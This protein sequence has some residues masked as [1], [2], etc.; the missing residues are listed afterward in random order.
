MSDESYLSL[1]TENSF[2]DNMKSLQSNLSKIQAQ[3]DPK[4]EEYQNDKLAFSAQRAI[5]SNLLV[6]LPTVVQRVVDKPGQGSVYALTNLI[7][8]IN[9]LFGQLRSSEAL[10]NQ[11]EYIGEYIIAPMLKNILTDIFDLSFNS[12]KQLQQDI[13]FIN[14]PELTKKAFE[15]IDQILKGVASMINKEQD[16]AKEKLKSYL[17]EV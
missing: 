12:K 15:S 6:L 4:S 5:L 1:S 8:Q 9:D 10:E 13:N 7:T 16:Q 11:V 2:E 3:I 14:Q 17:L